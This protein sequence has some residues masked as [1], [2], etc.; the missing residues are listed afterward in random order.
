MS[1]EIDYRFAKTVVTSKVV[2][3]EPTASEALFDLTLPNEAFIT[4]FKLTINGKE[5]EGKVKEK[6]QAK[7]EFEAAKSKG[8]SAG[9]IVA[10]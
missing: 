5:I 8:Q 2:N 7:Q 4:A 1:S 3:K 6:E 10:K 9:H